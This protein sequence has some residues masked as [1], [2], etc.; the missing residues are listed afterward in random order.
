MKDF[1]KIAYIFA[2]NTSV[3]YVHYNS[4][5]N[6]VIYSLQTIHSERDK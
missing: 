2:E 6:P 3:T 5:V 1:H 4:D